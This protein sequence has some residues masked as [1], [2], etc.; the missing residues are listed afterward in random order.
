MLSEVSVQRRSRQAAGKKA[1]VSCPARRVCLFD[2]QAAVFW[3]AAR[4]PPL[5]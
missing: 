3:P 1:W 5:T 2:S 4:Q